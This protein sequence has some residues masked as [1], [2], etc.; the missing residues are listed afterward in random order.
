MKKDPRIFLEHIIESIEY[1]E[2][3]IGDATENDFYDDVPMQDAAIRRLQVIGEAVKNL[4]Y[5]YREQHAEIE[6]RKAS[7]M[8]DVIVHEYFT[9]DLQLVW[10]VIKNE[11]PRFK[12]KLEE[13]L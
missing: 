1:I 12:N 8:R 10:N 13:L 4:P 5:E 9:I 7:G 11:L 2:E 3:N 6:W